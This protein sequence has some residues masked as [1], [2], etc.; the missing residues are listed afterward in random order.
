MKPRQERKLDDQAHRQG[1]M[2]GI[3][4]ISIF[5]DAD[6]RKVPYSSGQSL[7]RTVADTMKKA[8]TT[9]DKMVGVNQR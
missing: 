7:L 3:S 1:I 2:G 5:R 6:L 9:A 8:A 4:G